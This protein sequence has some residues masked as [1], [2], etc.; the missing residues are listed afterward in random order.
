MDVWKIITV[1][2]ALGVS[3]ATLSAHGEKIT[4]LESGQESLASLV[5]DL[6]LSNARIEQNIKDIKQGLHIK[7]G[8]DV[9]WLKN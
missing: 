3:W 1:I 7:D 2:F 9:T 8:E 5:T 6:R 4:N